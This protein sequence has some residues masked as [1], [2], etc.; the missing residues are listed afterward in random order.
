MADQRDVPTARTARGA[1]LSRAWLPVTSVI[2]IIGTLCIGLWWTANQ[3]RDITDAQRMAREAKALAEQAAAVNEVQAR[4]LAA[5]HLDTVV[6]QT[7][8]AAI[9]AQLDRIEAQQH[10]AKP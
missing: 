4:D 7:Q 9:R 1:D 2:A 5:Q 8:L 6:I 10:G 3:A